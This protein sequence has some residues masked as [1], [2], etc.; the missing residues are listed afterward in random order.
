MSHPQRRIGQSI[1]ITLY[2]YLTFN[3]TVSAVKCCSRKVCEEFVS[4]YSLDLFQNFKKEDN[5][6]KEQGEWLLYPFEKIFAEHLLRKYFFSTKFFCNK[7]WVLLEWYFAFEMMSGS[8]R[9]CVWNS[10]VFK[11]KVKC[12]NYLCNF[13]YS[14]VYPPSDK[15]KTFI[16]RIWP[17]Q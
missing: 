11:R 14:Y 16:Q 13:N 5:I 10:H 12:L 8:N 6:E 7:M 3:R 2:R 9:Y 15:I 17:V 1:I 4:Y